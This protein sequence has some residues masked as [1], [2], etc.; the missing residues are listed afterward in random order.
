MTE[1]FGDLNIFMCQGDGSRTNTSDKSGRT[2][3]VNL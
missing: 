3:F 2:R 1:I